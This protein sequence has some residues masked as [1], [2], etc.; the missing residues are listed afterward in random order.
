MSCGS[1]HRCCLDPTLLWLWCRPA[2]A[3]LIQPLAW[4][5]T[6]AMSVNL[7]IK[8]TDKQKTKNTNVALYSKYKASPMIFTIGNKDWRIV[9]ASSLP[10]L[11]NVLHL[12][13]SL[14]WRPV[15]TFWDVWPRR[16]ITGEQWILF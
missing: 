11:Q 1:G 6:Y 10:Q 9:A 2:T 3:A 7:K 14:P 8:Q 16:E 12:L 15:T 5:P 4:E 13:H